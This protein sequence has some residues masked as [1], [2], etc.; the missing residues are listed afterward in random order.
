MLKDK[1]I[2]NKIMTESNIENKLAPT[3]QNSKKITIVLKN[4]T[5]HQWTLYI[6]WSELEIDK[7]DLKYFTGLIE[8]KDWE[9]EFCK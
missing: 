5:M 4:D 9:C 6:K 1:D 3:T 2:S 8:C 7:S